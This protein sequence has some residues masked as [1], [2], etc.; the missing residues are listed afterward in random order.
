MLDGAVIAEHAFALR[1]FGPGGDDRL[2]V[3]NLGTRL[4]PETIPEP[5]LAPP[6]QRRWVMSFSSESPEYGGW[7][8]PPVETKKHGWWIPAESAVLLRPA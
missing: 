8:T 6:L 3:V 1:F 2:L 4:R 7:G 5:L